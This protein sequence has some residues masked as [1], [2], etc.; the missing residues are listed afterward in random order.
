MAT[1]KDAETSV[2]RA[3][4]SIWGRDFQSTLVHGRQIDA[5]AVLD[6]KR[7]VAIEVTEKKDINKIQ[8]DLNKLIHVR[9]TNFSS[10]FIQTECLSVTAYEPTL[11]MRSAGKSINIDILSMEEFQARFLPF[12]IYNKARQLAPFGSAIDPDTGNKD[13][14]HY[15]SCKR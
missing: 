3:A 1:W 5:Y 7:C 2:R 8:E 9:Y 11:A 13:N 4:A 14:T 10:G 6:E 15:V 12:E